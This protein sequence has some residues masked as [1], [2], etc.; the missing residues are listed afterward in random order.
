MQITDKRRS[1]IL[2]VGC[3]ADSS[4]YKIQIVNEMLRRA[5]DLSDFL[6]RCR[7]E[8]WAEIKINQCKYAL[9]SPECKSRTVI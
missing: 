8:R 2:E 4:S 1:S 7:N 3:G 5:F 6:A 9:M